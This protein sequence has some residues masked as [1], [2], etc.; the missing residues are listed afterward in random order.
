MNPDGSLEIA[1]LA[2]GSLLAHPGEWLGVQ[3]TKLIRT[4][5]PFPVEY[6]GRALQR[7]GGAPTMVRCASGGVVRG[8]LMVLPFKNTPANLS[9]VRE[10]LAVR[11]GAKDGKSSKIKE[12]QIIGFH[13]VY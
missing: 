5:T 10:H 11:E 3:M 9:L 12:E 1:V 4:L 7:R 8:A 13:A 2:Y 6:A